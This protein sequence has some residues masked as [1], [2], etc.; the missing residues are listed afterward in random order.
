MIYF[1]NGYIPRIRPRSMSGLLRLLKSW[2]LALAQ[3]TGWSS[4]QSIGLTL[5]YADLI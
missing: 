2:T 3:A 5:N 1:Y 4:H